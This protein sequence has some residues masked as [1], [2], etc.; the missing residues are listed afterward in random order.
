MLEKARELLDEL[1][2]DMDYNLLEELEELAVKDNGET[3]IFNCALAYD[4]VDEGKVKL[5]TV[6]S[7]SI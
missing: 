2:G 5:E 4:F 3:F 7:Y 1:D 6:I